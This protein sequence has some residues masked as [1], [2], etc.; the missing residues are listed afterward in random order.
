MTKLMLVPLAAVLCAACASW[1]MA[2]WPSLTDG[3]AFS[4]EAQLAPE[5]AAAFS[6]QIE[7]DLAARGARVAIVFRT[8]RPLDELPEGLRYLHGAL[9]V[10]R[11][12]PFVDGT[13]Q[14]GYVVYSLRPGDGAALPLT[15]SAL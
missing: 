10:Y 3:A 1:P 8:G 4:T 2:P 11:E 12:V 5:E 7:R 13:T 9:W 15:E 14:R 6:K